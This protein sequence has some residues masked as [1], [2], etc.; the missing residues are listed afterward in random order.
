[1]G[2]VRIVEEF[3]ERRTRREEEKRS[4]VRRQKIM[5][6]AK[7]VQSPGATKSAKKAAP[8][9]NIFAEIK[10]T[11]TMDKKMAHKRT[12]SPEITNQNL[13]K[14]RNLN[15]WMQKYSSMSPRSI[16]KRKLEEREELRDVDIIHSESEDSRRSSDSYCVKKRV[17]FSL[18]P[19]SSFFKD[20]QVYSKIIPP[21][22]KNK[23]GE[24][25]ILGY[26]LRFYKVLI[27]TLVR[28]FLTVRSYDRIDI[29]SRRRGKP[30]RKLNNLIGTHGLP[31]G[32]HSMSG[33]V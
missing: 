30:I 23:P 22:N 6:K 16:L 25:N 18:T 15:Y 2:G 31:S 11:I 27:F 20:K 28:I 1:M 5:E 12:H 7:I 4:R 26:V 14:I 29:L 9:G 33:M 13:K 3:K 8:T 24:D 32:Y 19:S 17:R 21:S 10:Y